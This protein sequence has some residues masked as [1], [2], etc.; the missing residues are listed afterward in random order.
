MARKPATTRRRRSLYCATISSMSDSPFLSA[1]SA[2]ICA[3]MGA[4]SM[5][6]WWIFVMAPMAS[7][8]P[9]AL[10][11]RQPVLGPPRHRPRRPAREERARTIRDIARLR[12]D[13][14][15]ARVQDGAQRQ[16]QP[17]ADAARDQ[18]LVLR[19]VLDAVV[20][21]QVGRHRLPQLQKAP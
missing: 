8:G 21:V 7:A 4:E 19:V 18:H 13:H 9:A 16:V 5:V 11:L 14:L 20:P 2:A 6:Y 15:V 3:V 1:S 12:D 10:P 17:L